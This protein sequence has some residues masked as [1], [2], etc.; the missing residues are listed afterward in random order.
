MKKYRPSKRAAAT[1]YILLTALLVLITAAI[2]L[3]IP[4]LGKYDIYAAIIYWAFHAYVA[5]VM[6][7]LYFK[8]SSIEVSHDEIIQTTG[9]LTKKSEYMPM[10]SVKSVTTIVTPMSRLTGLNFI[11]INALGS[12]IILSFMR[13]NDCTEATKYINDIIK[14]RAKPLG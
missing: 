12:K 5:C 6:I 11:I 7:P 3:A 4:F 9:M 2:F 13:K 1:I 8:R 14:S 10:E